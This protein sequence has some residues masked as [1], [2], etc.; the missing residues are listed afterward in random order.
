M[1]TFDFGGKTVLVTG[2]SQGIGLAAAQAFAK[3]GATVHITGTVADPRSYDADLSGFVY[4]RA[5]LEDRAHRQ[6]LVAAVPEVDV[7]VNNAGVARED[8]YDYAGFVQTIEI[9]L[10][11]VVELCYAYHDCL[12][13][14]A[15]VIVNIGSVAS[16]LSLRKF[17]GYTA[18]KAGL[19]GFTRASA[20]QWAID[21]IRVNLVAPGFID[22]KVIDWVK[23][24]PDQ[25]S[26]MMRTIPARRW[27]TPDEVAG[28]VLF[29]ASPEASYI[30]GQSLPVD[31]GLLL[32]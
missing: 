29:L 19:L 21:G 8:E 14:R 9:N 3:A 6:A 23:Q 32:R 28:A 12:A 22:T 7:L 20:D 2:A 31:G 13:R 25:G 16:F 17:P 24:L 27:G 30:T 18:S 5:R 1:I 10:N 11:A 4:H 26:A 15:G